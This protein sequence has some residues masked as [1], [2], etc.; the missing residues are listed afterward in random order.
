VLAGVVIMGGV[1]AAVISW[2][3]RQF[4]VPMFLAVVALFL[5]SSGLTLINGFPARLASLSTAQPLQLQIAILLGAG[6]VGLALMALAMGLI[7]GAVPIWSPSNGVRDH[8]SA[9]VLALAV[10]AIGAAGRMLGALAGSAAGP[11]W[12]NYT[13]A[14]VY[15]PFGAAALAP[16][17]AA[18]TR[19]V[20]LLL[21]GA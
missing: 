9:V 1:I 18:G 13:G 10:G 21:L 5:V 7:S 6:S 15:V 4:R 11:S 2:S 17:G 8:R 14:A 20:I 19:I 16:L 3:R 12:P